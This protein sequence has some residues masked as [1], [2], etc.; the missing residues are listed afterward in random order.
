MKHSKETIVGLSLVG[1]VA[2]FVLGTRFLA[3]IPLFG[4]V[5]TL[6]TS[7]PSSNGLIA[8]DAVRINGINLGAVDAVQLGP[9]GQDVHVRFHLDDKARLPEGSY[10]TLGG[11]PPLGTTYLTVHPGP[12][13]NALVPGD[14]FI[15]GI[16]ESDVLA[17]VAEQGQ[18]LTGQLEKTLSN[19]NTVFEGAHM[20]VGSD[21]RMILGALRETTTLLADLM[22]SE[23]Q[24]IRRSIGHVESFSENMARLSS[25]SSD[26]LAH[27]VHGLQGA[28]VQ[29]EASLA[30]LDRT[31]HSLANI[32]GKIDEGN[33]TL[34]LLVND[35][36]LYVTMD[37]T[38][39]TLNGHPAGFEE[40]SSQVSE[41]PGYCRNLL[42]GPSL[43]DS[44]GKDAGGPPLQ[45]ASEQDSGKPSLWELRALFGRTIRRHLPPLPEAPQI[46]SPSPPNR[47]ERTP[48]CCRLLKGVPWLLG[49]LFCVS[50]LWDF[51]GQVLSL[52][53]FRLQL[54]GLLRVPLDE[55]P[56]RLP[57]ELARDHNALP[58]PFAPSAPS[59]RA[60]YRL[61]ER[62]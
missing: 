50:F 34:G 53:G 21:T 5:Y 43:R 20:L 28:L 26:T 45:D 61:S 41:T 62:G 4:T 36:G 8:G 33:G 51:P 35:P 42:A 39:T 58:S 46:R 31:T 3:D 55:W 56:D 49:M 6:N 23:R 38:L 11:F 44:G 2:I 25:T 22:R 48:G 30:S 7:F 17:S 18:R 19:A 16:E 32:L 40:R 15:P 29:L 27:V 1:A 59:D 10:A 37:S 54:D 52:G 9:S 47:W 24:S 12:A 13:E 60:S 14:G 57:D